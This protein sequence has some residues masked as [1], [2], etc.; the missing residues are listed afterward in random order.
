[1]SQWFSE[2][3]RMRI[4]ILFAVHSTHLVEDELLGHSWETFR[5]A[6]DQ[7]ASAIRRIYD[8]ALQLVK[9]S[10]SLM[11]ILWPLGYLMLY[12]YGPITFDNNRPTT[13]KTSPLKVVTGW[14]QLVRSAIFVLDVFLIGAVLV[15]D[16]YYTQLI[17]WIH[18][19]STQLFSRY[20]GEIFEFLVDSADADGIRWI[21]EMIWQQ[22]DSLQ[23][24]AGLGR[25]M[26]CV[27]PP[28]A[29]DYSYGVFILALCHRLVYVY[30]S[31]NWRCLPAL[32]CGRFYHHRQKLRLRQLKVKALLFKH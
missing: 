5:T 4:G 27:H 28:P 3:V 18:T 2:T 32:I 21:G 15:V 17:E 30:V 31:A 8:I 22:L 12:L 29:A 11:L 10:A 9:H 14:I 16:F 23:Q 25:L 6:L 19:K 1:M 26:A 24:A 7:G 20:R 13:K